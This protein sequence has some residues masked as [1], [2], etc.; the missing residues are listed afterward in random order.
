MKK[1]FISALL[2][3]SGVFSYAQLNVAS[4][5]KVA[6]PEGVTANMATISPD[7][8]YVVLSCN[9]KA[10]L[11]KM[12]LATKS[13]TTI[14]EKGVPYGLQI[15]A[16]GSTVVY[17]ENVVGSDRLSRTALK[18]VKVA[19]GKQSTLVK[20]TRNLQGF[21]VRGA[22][23]MAMNDGKVATKSLTGERTAVAPVASINGGQLYVT[24][25]GKTTNISPQGKDCQSYIWPSI[26]PDGTKVAYYHTTT[27]CWVC[28]LDGSNPVH[29]GWIRSPKW[30]DN[31]AV[32][33][34]NDYD[35]GTS[36]TSSKIVAMSI[37][38][39]K[40]QNLTVDSSMAMYPTV[41]ADGSKISYVTP[42]GELYII[43]IT[44]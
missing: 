6:L 3:C 40:G 38:G 21:E 33:G 22:Q 8:S 44:K 31:S 7:G 15:S 25:N 34:M 41:N 30:Y 16:D 43:N 35:D 14:S 12:D 9:E 5:E 26:S 37:D 10:G 11:H 32:V 17:R 28:N 20:A 39:K 42:A 24:V 1:L 23:V 27:G 19:T 13:I 2:L 36:V 29:L 18:S 4:I